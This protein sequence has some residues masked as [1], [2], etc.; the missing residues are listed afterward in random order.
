MATSAAHA[1]AI[2]Q[3]LLDAGSGI[4]ATIDVD[5]LAR[6]G[7]GGRGGFGG[8]RSGAGFGLACQIDHSVGEPVGA[9]EVTPKC[10]WSSGRRPRTKRSTAF[11]YYARI[12]PA[13]RY[14]A[15]G[16]RPST[17]GQP[18]RW[19]TSTGIHARFSGTAAR[20]SLYT[21]PRFGYFLKEKMDKLGIECTV[22]VK[23]DHEGKPAGQ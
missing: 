20:A 6:M 11:S 2:E 22:R 23:D 15:S 3:L 17:V 5:N 16:R 10:R 13:V 8:W 14:I 21:N 18:P 1:A 19:R 7:F 9:A 4:T 12:V